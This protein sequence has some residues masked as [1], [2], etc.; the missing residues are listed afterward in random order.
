MRDFLN[1]CERGDFEGA[2]TQLELGVDPNSCA[3]KDGFTCVH[4][5]VWYGKVDFVKGLIESYSFSAEARTTAHVQ[6]DDVLLLSR[7]VV[8]KPGTWKWEMR[9]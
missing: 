3:T 7:R 6:K 9:N 8:V 5:G 4:H 2:R 1:C